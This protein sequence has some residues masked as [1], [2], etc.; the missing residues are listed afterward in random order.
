MAKQ[1]DS[2]RSDQDTSNCDTNESLEALA[3]LLARQLAREHFA[4]S[5]QQNQ[6]IDQSDSAEIRSEENE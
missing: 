4:G 1:P 3:R 6:R 5:I 2:N